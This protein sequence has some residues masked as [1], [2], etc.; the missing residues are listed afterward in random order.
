MFYVTIFVL[1]PVRLVKVRVIIIVIAAATLRVAVAVFC[2]SL[3]IT[4]CACS[5]SWISYF[6]CFG[7]EVGARV[8]EA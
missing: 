4:V 1:S 6:S 2:S 3:V 8:L 7:L 5:G